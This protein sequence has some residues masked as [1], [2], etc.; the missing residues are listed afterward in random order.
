MTDLYGTPVVHLLLVELIKVVIMS[1]ARR[2]FLLKTGLTPL[3]LQ[4]KRQL[5]QPWH[6]V[7]FFL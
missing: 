2:A 6:L 3:S 5:D 1:H 4:L 7:S